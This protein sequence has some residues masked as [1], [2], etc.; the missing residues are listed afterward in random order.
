MKLTP[1]EIDLFTHF[2]VTAP[3]GSK[4]EEYPFGWV[5]LYQA[6]ITNWFF[7]PEKYNTEAAEALRRGFRALCDTTVYRTTDEYEELISW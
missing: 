2:N 7:E 5:P 4:L 3:N 1:K 6:A